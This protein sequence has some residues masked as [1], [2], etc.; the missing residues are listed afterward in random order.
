MRAHATTLPV[1]TLVVDVQR[2]TC[3]WER[4]SESVCV[5]PRL[6]EEKEG[7][8]G[9]EKKPGCTCVCIR[10]MCVR[11]RGISAQQGNAVISWQSVFTSTKLLIAI[12][13]KSTVQCVCKTR[14]VFRS[15]ALARLQ[16]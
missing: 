1:Q 6:C 13:F 8:R 5:C 15:S 11:V 7:R 10:C 9:T 2:C 14:W 12:T 3:R 16:V 4:A